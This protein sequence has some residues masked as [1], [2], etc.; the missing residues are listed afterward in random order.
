[1]KAILAIDQGT[2]STRAIAF[3]VQGKKL[4]SSKF[5]INSSEMKKDNNHIKNVDPD[6]VKAYGKG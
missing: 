1:M 6:V 2:T 4:Y 5:D 3:S